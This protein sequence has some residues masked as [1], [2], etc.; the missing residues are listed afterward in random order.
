MCPLLLLAPHCCR[1]CAERTDDEVIA[2]REAVIAS[3]EEEGQNLWYR[4]LSVSGE[5]VIASL[6]L[7]QAKWGVQKVAQKGQPRDKEA[8]CHGQRPIVAAARTKDW[9]PSYG[10]RQLL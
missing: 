7:L 4:F 8:I 5:R 2:E 9:P 10:M 3:I 6:P 1:W